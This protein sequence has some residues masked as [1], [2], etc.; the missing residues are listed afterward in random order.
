MVR[1]DTPRLIDIDAQLPSL[2]DYLQR[3][4]GLAAAF[5]YGSYGTPNQTPRSDVDLALLFEPG[6]EIKLAD[7]LRLEADI[8]GILR[9]DDVNVLVLNQAP[10]PLRFAVLAQN[11]PLL[12]R[13]PEAVADFHELV[14][15]IY[16]DLILDLE[17]FDRDTL[18]RLEESHD[19]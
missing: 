6:P 1:G 16:G 8:A 19:A 15:N 12:I 9:E 13:H 11:R 2:V 17:Q 10:V 4:P 5:L 18:A 7:Q 3:Y 14:L